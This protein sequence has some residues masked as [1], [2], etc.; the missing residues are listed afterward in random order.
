MS[1]RGSLFPRLTVHLIIL[2]YFLQ[3]LQEM[4][5]D[6]DVSLAGAVSARTVF[7]HCAGSQRWLEETSAH[8]PLDNLSRPDSGSK[9]S[10]SHATA[11][12]PTVPSRGTNFLLFLPPLYWN[13]I[14]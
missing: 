1:E 7:H 4:D 2:R 6:L 3:N 5:P 13:L 11:V 14:T 9:G 12:Q 10:T 8:G